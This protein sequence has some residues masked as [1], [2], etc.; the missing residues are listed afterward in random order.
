MKP[1]SAEALWLVWSVSVLLSPIATKVYWN[2]C[3][4][5]GSPPLSEYIGTALFAPVSL[6]PFFLML[7][8]KLY[9]LAVEDLIE[10]WKDTKGT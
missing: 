3:K 9:D 10:L 4:E 5:P 6:V 7:P 2:I 1:E 8:T